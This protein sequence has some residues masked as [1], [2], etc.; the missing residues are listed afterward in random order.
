MLRQYEEV[1][2][3][4]NKRNPKVDIFYSDSLNKENVKQLDS[5]DKEILY[6]LK[7]ISYEE[8]FHTDFVIETLTKLGHDIDVVYDDNGNFAILS[9]IFAPLINTDSDDIE[10]FTKVY[11]NENDFWSPT[12][13]EA[14]RIYL[15][16]IITTD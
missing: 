7:N 14:I 10:T 1:K 6:L 9:C 5:I 3:L 11:V 16:R 8:F 2:Q 4:L 12:I 13:K 15:E